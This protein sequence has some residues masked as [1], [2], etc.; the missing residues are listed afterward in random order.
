MRTIRNWLAIEDGARA[1]PLGRRGYPAAL[2]HLARRAVCIALR[3][4]KELVSCR[5]LHRWLAP[6]IPEGLLN[7]T[8]RAFRAHLRG[9]HAAYL[10]RRRMHTQVEAPLVLASLDSTYLGTDEHGEEVW[11][12]HLRDVAT[13]KTLALECV[14]AAR[15]ERYVELLEGVRAEHGELPL[16]LGIDNGPAERSELLARYAAQHQIVLL[17]NEPRTPE[18]N[19]FVERGHQE[20]KAVLDLVGARGKHARAPRAQWSEDLAWAGYAVDHYLPRPRLGGKTAE[21]A[22]QER[23]ERYDPALRAR[24]YA[25]TCA[26]LERALQA[27]PQDKPTLR[28]RR[29]AERAAVWEILQDFQ[30]ARRVRGEAVTSGA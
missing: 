21:E 25:A 3:G 14:S 27:L 6:R 17:F 28:A 8:L 20:L 15:G 9:L 7:E 24:L 22:W 26:A 23:R 1:T 13:S 4:L 18:H 12:E 10:A 2:V 16:V 5:L 19:S 29:R 30:V 11:G